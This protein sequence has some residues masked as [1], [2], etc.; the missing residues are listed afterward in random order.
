MGSELRA[1]FSNDTFDKIY[2]RYWKPE[3]EKRKRSFLRMFWEKPDN[4]D[5]NVHSAFRRRFKDKMSLRKKVKH[6][7]ASYN[8]MH[9]LWNHSFQ[10]VDILK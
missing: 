9:D 5:N 4:Q 2:N 7:Q 6:E 1:R 3:K 8:K 10:V